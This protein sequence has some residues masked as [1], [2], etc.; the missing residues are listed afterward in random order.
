MR[1]C[2]GSRLCSKALKLRPGASPFTTA[3]LRAGDLAG[4][5]VNSSLRAEGQKSLMQ[6]H[7]AVLWF[8][9]VLC[10][11]RELWYR[12][13][14]CFSTPHQSIAW[15]STLR[16]DATVAEKEACVVLARFRRRACFVDKRRA[17]FEIRACQC[18]RAGLKPTLK[19]CMYLRT[20]RV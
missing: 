16:L 19:I 5:L 7:R 10:F 3:A 6:V 11:R 15:L 12:S 9:R 17:G 2:C 18:F 4:V 1:L 14:G 8:G 13:P 20:M